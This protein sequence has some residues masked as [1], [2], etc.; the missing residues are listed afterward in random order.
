MYVHVWVVCCVK[1][2]SF[3]VVIKSMGFY[4]QRINIKILPLLLH[5]FYSTTSYILR[6]SPNPLK[7]QF[8]HVKKVDIIMLY[9]SWSCE[10][11][12]QQYLQGNFFKVTSMPNLGLKL[13]TPRSRISC[14]TDW[15][16]QSPQWNSAYEMFS[17]VLG[18][19]QCFI[20]ANNY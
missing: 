14:S 5:I 19:S 1:T 2:P 15:V 16:I 6:E 3:N 13:K 4:S 9:T 7:H 17:L 20:N 10:N 18:T 11:L 8:P 12:V